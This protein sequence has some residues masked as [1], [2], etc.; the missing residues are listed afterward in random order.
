MI[1]EVFP[2]LVQFTALKHPRKPAGDVQA[3]QFEY[4]ATLTDGCHLSFVDEMKGL[5][6]LLSQV[7][8]N[9]VR[10]ETPFLHGDRRCSRQGF[11]GLIG[12]MSH[13]ADHENVG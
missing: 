8:E 6:W 12:E 5:A 9:A 2:R 7:V 11:T 13:I 4:G 10:N 3:A 1:A